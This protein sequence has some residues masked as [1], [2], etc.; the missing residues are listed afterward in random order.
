MR[1]I[2]RPDRRYRLRVAE[3][4]LD[5]I[6]FG[7]TGITGRRVAAYLAERSPETGASWAA[8][9]RDAAK[10]ERVLD[11]DGVTAPETI[12]ADVDDP[13]SLLAMASRGKVVLDLVGPYTRFGRPVIEAC[14]EGGAQYVDLTGEIP[15]VRQVID[16]FDTRAADAGVKVVQVCGFESL[17]PDLA[18]LLATETARER[19]DESLAEADLELVVEGPPGAPRPS[20]ISGGTLQSVAEIAASEDASI[21]TD[22]AALITDPVAAAEVRRRSPTSVA[23][24]RSGEAVIAPM[25]P[26]AFMNP[27]VVHR[28]AAL[29]AAEGDRAFEPFRYREGV[30]LRGSAATLPLRYAAAGALSGFQAL[31][32]A[33]TRTP[34]ST[35]RRVG[36]ALRRVLP[37]SGFGPSGDRLDRWRWRISLEARTTGS[38]N[39]RIEVDAEGHPGYLATARMLGEVGLLLAEP[40]ATPD[41]AGCLTPATA[42]GTSGIDRFD[43]A[44]VRFSVSP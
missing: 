27:P 20:D 3:R 41:R 43:R 18:V 19:W 9:A 34:P 22:P 1:T 12:V 17:P 38:R 24:R 33:A 36:S 31:L 21:F 16:E 14:V 5:V 4:E 11:E 6:V 28:S 40:D 7:A 32:G 30:A 35:R 29:L 13:E 10:V 23:P 8:A 44:R 37:S 15:F 42:V 39:V 2:P 25:A 26:A